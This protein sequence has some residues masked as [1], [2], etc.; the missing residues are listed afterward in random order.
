[1]ARGRP[2]ARR[3][4]VP[5]GCRFQTHDHQSSRPG[6]GGVD[7]ELMVRRRFALLSAS[8]AGAPT[9]RQV[10]LPSAERSPASTWIQPRRSGHERGHRATRPGGPAP[11]PGHR[12]D[13]QHRLPALPA[14]LTHPAGHR[15]RGR[16]PLDP[17]P[18][19]VRRLDPQPRRGHQLPGDL[20]R[21]LGGG[22][23][24]LAGC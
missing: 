23:A 5:T 22:A 15:R 8:A 2:P 18:V 16:R 13:P 21:H 24:G 11:P 19:P 20:H 14:A 9:A 6:V 3:N 1:M 4:C 17:A 12:R 10:P 7:L